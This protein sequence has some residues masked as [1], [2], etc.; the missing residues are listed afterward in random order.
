MSASGL[1]NILRI[2]VLQNWLS[3]PAAQAEKFSHDSAAMR[4]FARVGLR[5]GR[6]GLLLR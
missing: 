4:R 3:L 6:A 2:Y 1:E 5:V